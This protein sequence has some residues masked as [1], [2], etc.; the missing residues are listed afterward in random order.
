MG[1]L[2]SQILTDKST[3]TTGQDKFKAYD[4]AL[5]RSSDLVLTKACV[6]YLF[7]GTTDSATM[8]T[9]EFGTMAKPISEG[10][11][12]GG[13]FTN[14]KY[15]IGKTHVRCN[16]RKL[17]G[18]DVLDAIHFEV[19]LKIK[20][21]LDWQLFQTVSNDSDGLTNTYAYLVRLFWTLI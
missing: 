13:D 14:E 2:V 9:C 16:A 1:S 7:G 8:V 20:I 18:S 10:N 15:M 21:P 11:P 4:E 19:N 17:A 5:H 12:Q 6:N 3:L